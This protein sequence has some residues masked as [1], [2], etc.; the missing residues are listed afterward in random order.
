MECSK[1][2]EMLC[3]LKLLGYFKSEKNNLKR[4]KVSRNVRVKKKTKI[5]TLA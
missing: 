2:P 4:K 5:Q 1:K 3:S